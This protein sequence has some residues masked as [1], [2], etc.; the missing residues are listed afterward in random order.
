MKNSLLD[1][2]QAEPSLARRSV[3]RALEPR[4]AA[5]AD[6]VRRLVEASFRLIRE[7][8]QLEAPVSEIVR[9]A[10]LSNHAF[11]KHFRSK[12]ELLVTLLDD[13]M[14]QLSS[15]LRHRMESASSPEQRIR[16]WIAGMCEQALNARA[17]AATRPFA[18]SRA[19]LA[20]LFPAEVA[21]SER[22]LTALLRDA[23]E[24]AIAT[25]ALPPTDAA[26]EAETLYDLAMGWMQRMLAQPE[27]PDRAVAEHLVEFAMHGLARGGADERAVARPESASGT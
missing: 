3:E 18:L 23:I 13:G 4:R 15:Y 20:E 21:K 14:R 24:A 25:G 2:S 6:E 5:Y 1:S 27:P 7:S 11:Y 8:G 17:A 19:R 22:R 9:A 26:R 12:D 16:R 10:G